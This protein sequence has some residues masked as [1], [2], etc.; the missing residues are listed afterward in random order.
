VSGD[1]ALVR[2][3][4]DIVELV[5]QRVQLKRAGKHWKGLCPFHNDRNPS[6]QVSPLTGTYRCWSCGAHG[7]CF[8][9][10]MET[11]RV[12]FV[13]ALRLLAERAGVRLTGRS[14][15]DRSR[16]ETHEQAMAAALTFF[17]EQLGRSKEAQAYCVGRGLDPATLAHWEIG[18]APDEG[19]ALAAHLRKQSLPLAEAKELYLVDGDPASGYFD[20]FRGRL[21]FPIR[22][23]HGAL[24]AFGG[25]LL[26]E[27]Q[28]KYVNSSDTPLFGKRHVLYGLFRAK[29]AMARSG[30]CVLVEGYLDVIACHR[31][32]LQEAVA[33]LGTSLTEEHCKALARW[34]KE[35]VVLFDSDEAGRKAADRAAD[36]LAA[37]GLRVRVALLPQGDDPDTLLRRDA[38]EALRRAAGDGLSPL[39]FRIGQIRQR[40]QPDDPEFWTEAVD[41]MSRSSDDF[42]VRKF[43]LQLGAEYPDL[44]DPATAARLLQ[45]RVS[46]RRRGR[47][48]NPQAAGGSAQ[49]EAP[50][51]RA[52]ER[53]LLRAIFDPE[54]AATAW[55][56]LRDVDLF[57]TTAAFE[58]ASA[59]RDAFPERDPTEPPSVWMAQRLDDRVRRALADLEMAEVLALNEPAVND[60]IH[61][62]RRERARRQ[63][64]EV[65]SAASEDDAA[66][67]ELQSRLRKLKPEA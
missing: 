48:P 63:A 37:G 4:I 24:V 54:L 60:A 27:G 51:M 28:P 2:S 44:R 13:D 25:R 41:A 12:E 57:V 26:G 50:A 67:L 42:E 1:V 11:E 7:D 43:V 21:T 52:Q 23:T 30:R 6:F 46:E 14:E 40:L 59:L 10:V 65:R 9:W 61:T 47:A 55:R 33:S 49:P 53:T 8:T 58:L 16:R 18:Y 29:E 38:P 36:T 56:A 62:L 19:T 5:G 32:G 35:A 17:R 34:A 66:L 45:R 15:T 31:A 22:N 20:R 3:R 64:H 39:A